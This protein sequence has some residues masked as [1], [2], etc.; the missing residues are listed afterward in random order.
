MD[1]E[2]LEALKEDWEPV[3]RPARY[4]WLAFYG[5]FYLYAVS[6]GGNQLFIDLVFLPIHEGGHLFFRWFGSETLYIAG[7]TLMQ[8]GVPLALAVYFV[9]QRQILGAAFA[10]FFFFENFLNVG[11][12]MSDARAHQ[13]PL[14][15]VGDSSTVIHDW[16]YLFGKFGLLRFDTAIGGAVRFLGWTGMLGVMAWLW[17]TARKAPRPP[18]NP[19][20][21]RPS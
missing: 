18:E 9:F 14:V 20:L 11:T 17:W 7:G 8:L 5:L 21:N 15:T 2:F 3:S 12:Y 10:A 13:L 19:L 4:A 1:F 16:T 6:R